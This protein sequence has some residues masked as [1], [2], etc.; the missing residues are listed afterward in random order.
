VSDGPVSALSRWSQRKHA[1][2]LAERGGAAPTALN[3][4][5]DDSAAPG[6]QP[7]PDAPA[8]VP[9]EAVAGGERQSEGPS[10]DA[11]APLPPIEE[12]TPESDYTQ[13]LAEHVPEALQRAALRKLWT[14][15]PVLACLDGLN[16]YDEDFNVV[17]TVISAAETNYKVDR[18]Y[19]TVDEP[20][21]AEAHDPT[22]TT[23]GPAEASRE[24]D[25]SEGESQV[26]PVEAA[27]AE[28]D[29]PHSSHNHV[30]RQNVADE[31]GEVPSHAPQNNSTGST[32]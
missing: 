5:A 21:S 32:G 11:R 13:F 16:D 23:A 12:L 15:D 3:E 19:L 10:D 4:Q 1:A 27:A 28:D 26:R 18:G 29:S 9:A 6:L 31:A 22:V 17:D 20:E 24:R 8:N 7:A 25:D 2:R 30:T 14:S